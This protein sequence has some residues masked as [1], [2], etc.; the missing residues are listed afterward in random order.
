M[1]QVLHTWVCGEYLGRF[2]RD[3]TQLAPR[4]VYE[5]A[6]GADLSL[7]LPREGEARPR[8]ARIFLEGLLPEGPGTRETIQRITGAAS[9]ESWDLLE[10]I[11]GDLQGGVVLHS[12]RDGPSLVEP[13]MYAALGDDVADRILQIRRGGS[14]YGNPTIPARFSIAGVQAKFTLA[15]TSFGDFWTDS[16][17]PS[18]HIMKP[19]SGRHAG[20]ERIEAATLDLANRAGVPAP[21]AEQVEFRGETTF[22]VARFDRRVD[23]DGVAV[24]LHAEDLTQALGHAGDKYLVGPEDVVALLREATGDDEEGYAFYRQYAF[25]TL[26]GNA[27]AHG[28]NYSVLHGDDGVRLSPLYDTFP[29]NMFPDYHSDLAMPVGS[30][31]QFLRVTPADWIESATESGL[32]P[33]RVRTIVEAVAAGIHE[34]LDD[35]LGATGAPRATREALDEIRESLDRQTGVL[36]RC[37]P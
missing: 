14:G 18:T 10:A 19:E 22:Q 7:S 27:D 16:A 12:D 34:H 3:G 5:A 25:N 15:R 8:A 4:F 30:A 33:D 9:T 1:T 11:G 24:R 13:F 23:D 17:T 21:H 37:D 36:P 29:L 31:N 6:A 26:I 20:L 32:D 2:E 35:T 28:K